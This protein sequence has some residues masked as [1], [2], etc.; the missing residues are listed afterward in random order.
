MNLTRLHKRETSKMG[1]MT[2]DRGACLFGRSLA[3]R[4]VWIL[5]H[6]SRIAL[7]ASLRY[8]GATPPFETFP[9]VSD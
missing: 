5:D 9:H 4:A 2:I 1:A 3:C 6:L 8:T 7:A